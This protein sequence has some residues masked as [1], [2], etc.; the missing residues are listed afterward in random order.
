MSHQA[1]PDSPPTIRRSSLFVRICLHVWSGIPDNIYIAILY[2][3]IVAECE[4][5]QFHCTT[6]ST[7]SG[8]D[9]F[10]TAS[11]QASLHT[12][13]HV[14]AQVPAVG[15]RCVAC[16][17][18]RAVQGTQRVLLLAGA[19]AAGA[20]AAPA[21]RQLVS[22]FVGQASAVFDA[23]AQHAESGRQAARST[24]GRLYATGT[25]GTAKHHCGTNA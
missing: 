20:A 19:A 12:Q 23:H 22:R 15:A 16:K 5:V 25:G 14:Q 9:G 18:L 10:F 1:S 3:R 13:G 2:I 8:L 21:A 11:T 17:Y 4:N 7:G 24:T 6:W